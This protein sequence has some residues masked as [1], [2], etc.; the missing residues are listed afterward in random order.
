MKI[1]LGGVPFGCD[2]IGDEAILASVIG[3]VRGIC[4]DAELLVSTGDRVGAERKFGL[5]TVPLYGFDPAVPAE[6]LAEALDRVDFYIWAG[7]TGLSDYPEMACALLETA[8]AKGVRTIVWGV[9]MNDAFN[10][11]FFTL[12]GKKKKISDMLKACCGFDMEKRWIERRIRAVR[13]RLAHALGRCELIV[14]RDPKS[15][16]TL[17]LCAPFPDAVAGADTAILQKQCAPEALPWSEAERDLFRSAPAR[18]AVCVSEQSRIREF[19]KFSGW[20][21]STL[22]THPE[23]LAVTVPMNP[24]TDFRV[25]EEMKRLSKH[26]DRILSLRFLEPEEVQAV[27]AECSVIVSS[28]LHLLILGLNNLV[29]GVG[30]ARGSKIEYF[31]SRFGLATA[32]STDALDLPRLTESVEHALAHQNEFKRRAAS[33]RAGLLADLGRA[34]TL[35]KRTL[36]SPRSAR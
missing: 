24:K 14:L 29:P 18:M 23:L 34:E 16:E 21:D 5:K 28:R 12:H 32:G 4:P 2:N 19:D 26:P 30:I 10:P 3:L 22:E 31:L 7:A 33:V 27:A 20:L 1:L 36:A 11:A 17:R 35:L 9:G 13:R 6:R 25:M 15:L 8:Q